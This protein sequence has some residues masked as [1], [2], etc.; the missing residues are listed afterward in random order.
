VSV[1]R[2][3]ERRVAFVSR[4]DKSKTEIAA[5][6]V[7][8]RVQRLA[9]FGPPPLLEGEDAAAYDQPLARICAAA[10]PVDIIDEM[11]IA[12]VVSL[13]W[14]VLRWR[15]L[16]SS[17]IRARGLEALKG[18]LA[19]QLDY[20]LYSEHFAD[21]LAEILRD[22]DWVEVEDAQTLA[23][24]CARNE[25][26]A[27]DQVNEWLAGISLDVDDILNGARARKAKE[28]VQEYVRREPDAVTLIHQLL[29]GA[30]VSMDG[31]TAGALSRHLDDIER[32]DRLTTIA[33]SRR[34]VSL[35]EIDRRRAVL[36]ETL[37]RGVQEIEDGEFEA[38]ETTP[39]KESN[40]A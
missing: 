30:G 19:G 22:N 14:E 36:G 1:V 21:Q 39:A 20:D 9:L 10:K 25:P 18:F 3:V 33:E 6:S 2:F 40:V 16:K 37:R 23:R 28:L 24:E 17:L 8:E 11:F 7:P 35:H 4:N 31:L 5:P 29:T 34:N 27:I 15:R 38:I 13:E 32:I 12:D 26:D